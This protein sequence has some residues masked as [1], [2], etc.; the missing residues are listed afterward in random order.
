[1]HIKILKAYP[2]I[3]F[4]S[5]CFVLRYGEKGSAIRIE[6]VILAKKEAKSSG[7]CPVAKWV[8]I[9]Y[10]YISKIN[11]PCIKFCSH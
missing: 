9:L 4:F 11:F 7:G 2:A 8:S 6:K 10:L 5:L 1:M 3:I